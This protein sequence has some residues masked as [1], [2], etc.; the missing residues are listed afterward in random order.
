M[1]SYTFLRGE[2]RQKGVAREVRRKLEACEMV[3]TRGKIFQGKA[4]S[5]LGK[6]LRGGRVR[7]SRYGVMQVCKCWASDQEGQ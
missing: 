6:I 3:E 5:S 2:R 4:S 7:R 1:H